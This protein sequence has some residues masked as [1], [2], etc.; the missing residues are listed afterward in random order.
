MSRRL[1]IFDCDGTLVDSELV[2][3]RVFTRY[4]STHGVH[5]TED[6]FKELFI[7]T[8]RD[9]AIVTETFA[10]MPPEAE[11]TGNLL[12]KEA[13]HMELRPITG[14]P[15]VL[16]ALREP[17]CVA[18]NSSREHVEQALALCGLSQHFEGKVFSAHNVQRPKPAPDLFLRAASDLGFTPHECIVVEDSPAGLLAAQSAGMKVIA[19]AGAGHFVPKLAKRLLDL[20]PDWFCENADELQRRLFSPDS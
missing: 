3:S 14:I 1:I 15:E 18:S 11:A 10:R 4:W 20:S 2:A 16:N 13:L 19:F 6:E 9:A 12:F 17:V 5:F 8:G 7:G